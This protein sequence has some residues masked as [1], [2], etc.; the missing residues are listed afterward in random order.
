[1]CDSGQKPFKFII[2]AKRS[3]SLQNQIWL[4]SNIDKCVKKTYC[5][6]FV[7]SPNM[8]LSVGIC[9]GFKQEQQALKSTLSLPSHTHTST[10]PYSYFQLPYNRRELDQKYQGKLDL[11]FVVGF[12]RVL[13]GI[14]SKKKHWLVFFYLFDIIFKR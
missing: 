4:K 7:V 3:L 11:E 9:T 12:V 8:R 6:F 13:A 1:M 5:L 14:A 10:F 2:V